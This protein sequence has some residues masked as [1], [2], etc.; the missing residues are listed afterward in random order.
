MEPLKKNIFCDFCH[1]P[2]YS[3]EQLSWHLTRIHGIS[4]I[5]ECEICPD[6]YYTKVQLRNHL[7]KAHVPS[8]QLQYSCKQCR[9]KFYEKMELDMHVNEKH[10]GFINFKCKILNCGK[11]FNNRQ[12]LSEHINASHK[13][14]EPVQKSHDCYNRSRVCCRYCK[15][16]RIVG[17]LEFLKQHTDDCKKYN[18]FVLNGTR[19]IFCKKNFKNDLRIFSH[20]NIIHTKEIEK[21]TE[22][23]HY[24]KELMLMSVP[25]ET[26]H[27]YYNRVC[28]RY[29]KKE[30]SVRPRKLLK[31]HTDNCKKYNSF[32]LN[33][34][35]CIFCKKNFADGRIF[36]HFKK[37]HQKAIQESQ[38]CGKYSRI[39][40]RYCKKEMILC[41]LWSLKS[42]WK[43]T[44][45]CKKYNTYVLN[46]TSCI[47][48]KK[49]FKNGGIFN[50]LKKYHEKEIYFRNR[51]T[52]DATN[53]NYDG[54]EETSNSI[55][56]S[57]QSNEVVLK[58]HLEQEICNKSKNESKH[59]KSDQELC[60]KYNISPCRVKLN[61]TLTQT[62]EIHNLN[63][64]KTKPNSTDTNFLSV[65]PP[66][67][68][69]KFNKIIFIK[70]NNKKVQKNL[71]FNI[72]IENPFKSPRAT[73]LTIENKSIPQKVQ[74]FPN[75]NH[76]VPAPTNTQKNKAE[77]LIS[78]CEMAVNNKERGKIRDISNMLPKATA[79]CE[80]SFDTELKMKT[81]IAGDIEIVETF[82]ICDE[83]FERFDQL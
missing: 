83:E 33:G 13:E 53:S 48:C 46:G 22:N 71:A 60:L 76:L 39:C 15:K 50:H 63:E 6:L 70:V 20:L 64:A 66:K 18:T 29:C 67:P 27:D 37:T 40:C 58:C 45:N 72:S 36:T 55:R 11:L 35:T 8:T 26:S 57:F 56:Q 44:D 3:V 54:T 59:Q 38:N 1:K 80:N 19:C 7:K 47:L 62:N 34:T 12:G 21:I 79:K 4:D 42:L 49:N 24:E 78:D 2:C 68:E 69:N 25:V 81:E 61:R 14:N 75:P 32:V 16:E 9:E 28:C 10:V 82:H 77:N 41:D 30:K 65:S 52:L 5:F 51:S 74:I 73:K 17:S 31:Q 43:H 23:T